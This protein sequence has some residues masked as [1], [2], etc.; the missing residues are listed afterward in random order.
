MANPAHLAVLKQGVEKW[1]EWRKKLPKKHRNMRPDLSGVD[2]E[3]ANLKGAK[4]TGVILEGANLKGANF[5]GA[6]L[7][8]VRFRGANAIGAIFKGANFRKA[9]LCGARLDGADLSGAKIVSTTF[10]NN[11]LGSVKGLDTV[12]HLGPS[13][14]GI[15]TLYKSGGKIPEVFLRGSGVPEQL[16]TYLPALLDRAFEFYSCFISYSHKDKQFAHRLHDQ[17]Q[18]KGIRCWLDE[19]QLLPGDSLFDEVDLGIKLWDKVLLCAS[20]HS[21]TSW[22]VD[23][24]INKAFV[25]EQGLQ[26]ERG[27]KTLALIPLNLDGYLFKWNDGKADEVRSRLAADFTGWEKDNAKFEEQFER[28]VRALRADGSRRE[29][30]PPSRL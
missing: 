5:T 9:F 15:D 1:N 21:L 16:I 7:R 27:V 17:L 8:G 30:A 29:Q 18:A 23:N 14:I 11:E 2:I 28:V 4:L 19:K 13:T 25:K 10:G 6:V 22:W 24:E 20:E 26:K 3:A 12:L